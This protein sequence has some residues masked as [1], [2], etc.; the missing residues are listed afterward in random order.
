[1]NATKSSLLLTLV[2]YSYRQKKIYRIGCRTTKN[3][4]LEN[5]KKN[6]T[7]V[8]KIKLSP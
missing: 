8:I 7:E 4:T 1:M 6:L 3:K 2:N 5:F